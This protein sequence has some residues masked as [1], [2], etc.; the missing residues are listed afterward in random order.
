M[1]L[2]MAVVLAAMSWILPYTFN[3]FGQE[4]VI[5]IVSPELGK[6]Q[7]PAVVFPHEK[8]SDRMTCTRCHHEYDEFRSN[9]ASEDEGQ[10]CAECHTAHPAKNP[11]P[12][13][14]AFHLQCKGCHNQMAE[15]KRFNPP[16][17]CGGCHD[18]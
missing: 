13:M 15:T 16:R 5:K 18:R 14:K 6:H 4:E 1:K 3:A 17:T 12:L 11:I 7:R 10:R 2:K 9:R 8:H